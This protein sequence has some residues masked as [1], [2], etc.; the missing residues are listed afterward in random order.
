MEKRGHHICQVGPY[1]I[2]QKVTR[3]KKNRY[4]GKVNV[5][6]GSTEVSIYKSK[7][8]VEC[9]LK[10][11]AYAAQKIVEMMKTEGRDLSIIPKKVIKKYGIVI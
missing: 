9:N 4:Q 8:K 7:K 5:T 6:P 1:Q 10:S 11:V 2:R 3:A